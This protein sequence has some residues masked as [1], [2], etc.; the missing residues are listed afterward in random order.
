MKTGFCCDASTD[1]GATVTYA[2]QPAL[3]CRNMN[4]TSWEWVSQQATTDLC[5]QPSQVCLTNYQC[6]G[7][8]GWCVKAANPALGISAAYSVPAA[9]SPRFLCLPL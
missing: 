2:N 5:S 4:N 7:E 8:S 3:W 1:C 6:G 9:Y